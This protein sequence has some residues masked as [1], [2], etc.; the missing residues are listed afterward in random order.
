M[1]NV[2]IEEKLQR[3]L[4]KLYK[5]DKLRYELAMKK[6]DSISTNPYHYKPLR[7]DLKNIRADHIGSFVIV[8]RIVENDKLVKFLDFDHH[9]NIY[10]K[11][12]EEE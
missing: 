10:K 8:Y 11:R 4:K 9:D 12:F 1:Y 6:I 5:K 2:V 3:I 7:Y